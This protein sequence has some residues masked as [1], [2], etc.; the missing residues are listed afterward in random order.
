MLARRML[1]VLGLVGP[2]GALLWRYPSWM[3][4]PES[5]EKALDAFRYFLLYADNGLLY[6]TAQLSSLLS[7]LSIGDYAM[8]CVPLE[9]ARDK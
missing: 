2:K 6:S 4:L 9:E 1:L 5:R 8:Y 7:R 3:G